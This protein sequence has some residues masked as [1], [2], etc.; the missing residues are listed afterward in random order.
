MDIKNEIIKTYKDKAIKK[1]TTGKFKEYKE[2]IEAISDSIKFNYG[3]LKFIKRKDDKL[4][5]RFGEEAFYRQIL[6]EPSDKKLKDIRKSGLSKMFAY[7]KI[8]IQTEK[9]RARNKI[10]GEEITAEKAAQN[11]LNNINQELFCPN[12]YASF[13]VVKEHIKNEK[14]VKPFFRVK[15]KNWCCQNVITISI[16]RVL[17]EKEEEEEN[18]IK[19]KEKD[20]IKG[21][22]AIIDE[23]EYIMR[24]RGVLF[25]KESNTISNKVALFRDTFIKDWDRVNEQIDF[26]ELYLIIKDDGKKIKVEKIETKEDLFKIA[27][28]HVEKTK[29]QIKFCNKYPKDVTTIMNRLVIYNIDAL[30]YINKNVALKYLLKNKEKEI[31]KIKS[32]LGGTNEQ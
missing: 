2:N 8:G 6:E 22:V 15:K 7:S 19:Q 1:Y 11:N 17:E 3:F 16:N 10:T 14:P 30:E 5:G 9:T 13:T 28:E 31:K 4:Y 12:C 18:K 26:L 25:E 24:D 27:N 21:A 32:F 23:I 29:A 20:E